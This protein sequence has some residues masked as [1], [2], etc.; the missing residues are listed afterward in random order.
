MQGGNENRHGHPDSTWT[1]RPVPVCASRS[2]APVLRQLPE[3]RFH[4][5]TRMRTTIFLCFTPS[6]LCYCRSSAE[7]IGRICSTPGNTDP[8]S[9]LF[10]GPGCSARNP[11][12]SWFSV[13]LF[14]EPQC[15]HETLPSRTHTPTPLTCEQPGRR[16]VQPGQSLGVTGTRRFL[17]YNG[18]ISFPAMYLRS[19]W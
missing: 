1:D 8:L 16:A 12:N 11:T 9:G 19:N 5:V 10:H 2:L 3:V 18:D 6:G 17:T 15:S 13:W 7:H 14:E 4:F